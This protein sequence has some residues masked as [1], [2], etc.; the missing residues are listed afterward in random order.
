VAARKLGSVEASIMIIIGITFGLP[1]LVA[2]AIKASM[3]L[4]V[5]VWL[6][7]HAVRQYP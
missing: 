4:A 7:A 2:A 3:P 6:I 1:F 5:C